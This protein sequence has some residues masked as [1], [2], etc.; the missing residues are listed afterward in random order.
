VE[1]RVRSVIMKA[2]LLIFLIGI[3][4]VAVPVGI[5]VY[6]FSRTAKR[7]NEDFFDTPFLN[8]VYQVTIYAFGSGIRGF[9]DI[10]AKMMNVYREEGHIVNMSDEE[11]VCQRTIYPNRDTL[12]EL[13]AITRNAVEVKRVN[14]RE[15][16]YFFNE[17]RTLTLRSSRMNAVYT[18]MR[19]NVERNQ[20]MLM[21]IATI[22]ADEMDEA[23]E[24]FS[25]D[26]DAHG[27]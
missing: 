1:K 3:G 7:K 2:F 8:K 10:T 11:P 5:G 12:A 15:V 18:C 13:G 9:D 22:S 23:N 17:L 20:A 26:G 19:Q 16:Y 25:D 24:N 6:M 4:L 14:D 21:K 27:V